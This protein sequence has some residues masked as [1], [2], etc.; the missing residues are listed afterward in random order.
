MQPIQDIQCQKMV[1]ESLN[2]LFAKAEGDGRVIV[3]PCTSTHR[4]Q[5]I[6]NAS[7]KT[8]RKIAFSGRSMEK[9]LN[10]Y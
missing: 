3:Q 2:N 4:V 6:V 5:Q 10:R 7:G 9:I 1:G 8:G